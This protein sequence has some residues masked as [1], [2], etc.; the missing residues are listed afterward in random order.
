MDREVPTWMMEGPPECKA[1][2]EAATWVAW[3]PPQSKVEEA[4]AGA[5]EITVGKAAEETPQWVEEATESKAECSRCKAFVP[6][7]Q[8]PLRPGPAPLG[9]W[10]VL[11]RLAGMARAREE[12]RPRTALMA[13]TLASQAWCLSCGSCWGLVRQGTCSPMFI[14]V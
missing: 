13:I 10:R 14:S 3:E 11:G 9:M 7:Q 2:E 4:P 5:E 12:A 6:P 8:V 1:E